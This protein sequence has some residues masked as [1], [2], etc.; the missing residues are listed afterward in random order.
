MNKSLPKIYEVYDKILDIHH[1]FGSIE[2]ASLYLG[3]A[4]NKTYYRFN[5]KY[6]DEFMK[7]IKGKLIRKKRG[8]S[9]WKRKVL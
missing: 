7:L 1:H 3:W 9:K 5:H 6:E 4:Y 2:A 8:T